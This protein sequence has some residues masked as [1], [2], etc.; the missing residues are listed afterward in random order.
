MRLYS[1]LRA[2]FVYLHE[3]QLS[4]YKRGLCSVKLVS[5][6]TIGND[7]VHTKFSEI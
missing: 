6:L 4:V 2:K 1:I 3:L 5:M 7:N